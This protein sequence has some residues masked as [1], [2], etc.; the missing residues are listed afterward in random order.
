MI[1]LDEFDIPRRKY[2][3]LLSRQLGALYYMEFVAY[4]ALMLIMGIMTG[5]WWYYLPASVI[6]LPFIWY[7][8]RQTLCYHYGLSPENTFLYQKRKIVFDADK[9]HIQAE[10]GSEVHAS[11]N[12]ILQADRLGGYYRL[13]L[14]HRVAYFLIPISAFCS[15]EDRL[16]F[17]TE[18]LGNKMKTRSQTILRKAIRIFGLLLV[19]V[20]IVGCAYMFQTIYQ[21]HLIYSTELEE[22][23]E[24]LLEAE[25]KLDKLHTA[26]NRQ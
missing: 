18:I 13:L 23:N 12:H 14:L 17:E 7:G 3:E 21:S 5:D 9:F 11:L 24:K 22:T 16:R 26:N 15:A 4:V 10:D 20:C 19:L 25:R 2:L 6:G 8:V 1:E